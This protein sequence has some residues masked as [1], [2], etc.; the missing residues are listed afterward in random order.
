MRLILIGC[1]IMRCGRNTVMKRL[2][3]LH[4]VERG[5]A[6]AEGALVAV[7][8]EIAADVGGEA[9]L[10]KAAEPYERAATTPWLRKYQRYDDNTKS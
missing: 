4:D 1:A 2:P 9:A 3:R 10:A 5:I 7:R 6:V 8:D